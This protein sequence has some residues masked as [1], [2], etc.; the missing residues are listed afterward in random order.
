MSAVVATSSKRLRS[1]ELQDVESG[2]VVGE[3]HHALRIDKAVGG[4]DDLRPV[5]T[6]VEHPLW[7]GRHEEPSLARLERVLDV[8]DPDAGVVIGREDEARALES[9]RPAPCCTDWSFGVEEWTV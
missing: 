8:K 6:R 4:L 7:I 2:I 5:G 3:V 9:A 1:L